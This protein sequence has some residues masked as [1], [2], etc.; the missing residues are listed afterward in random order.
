MR[1]S[2]PGDLRNAFIILCLCLCLPS[3]SALSQSPDASTLQSYS[4]EGKKALEAG[5]YGEAERAFEKLRTLAPGI[6]EI[7]GQLGLIYFQERKFD[8]AVLA[9]RKAL[10]LNPELPRAGTLLALSLSELGHYEEALPGLEAGF[11]HTA[12]PAVQRICG[13]QLERAYT[14]LQRDGDAVQTAVELQRLFPTDPEILYR[15]GKVYGN[16]A[17]LTMRR[18]AQ[19]GSGSVWLH[20][21][22]AE[23]N[24][25]QGNYDSAV[26]EYRQVL[27]ADP[28]RPGIHYLLGRT[29][30]ARSRSTRNSADEGL[31]LKEFEQE[32]RLDA[33]NA[34]SAYEIGEIHRTSG[35]FT[36]AQKYFELSLNYYP[37]FEEAHLGL[38]S[39]L[40]SLRKPELALP[41]VQQAIALNAGNEVSWYRLSQAYRL[42]GNAPEQKR[43]FAEFQ[44]LRSQKSSQEA[45]QRVFSPNDVTRQELGSEL[46]H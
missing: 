44:R 42:L 35:E 2:R 41:H 24:E 46:A 5:D 45:E 37:A 36:E 39:T 33:G 16:S 20:L 29:L 10:Q 23:T 8:Q 19:S 17:L 21:A 22:E 18:L 14:S 25:S 26:I 15:T 12:E 7:H 30:L 11:R 27:A 3:W 43:A 31:A 34:S 4:A 28:H 9:L 32:L 13:L 38:A 40:I 1:P 6:A